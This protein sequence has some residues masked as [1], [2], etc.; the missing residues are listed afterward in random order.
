MKKKRPRRVL[1]NPHS[2]KPVANSATGAGSIKKL[3][4]TASTPHIAK[5]PIPE[6]GVNAKGQKKI[7]DP[8]G[9]VRFIDMKE[10]RVM[11]PG[12]VPVKG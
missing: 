9:K 1:L 3:P 2:S 12:G 10:G 5:D 7:T 8:N 6:G 4:T 11:G